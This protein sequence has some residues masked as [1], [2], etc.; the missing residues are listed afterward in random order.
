[1]PVHPSLPGGAPENVGTLDSFATAAMDHGTLVLYVRAST[2]SHGLLVSR[3]GGKSWT[4][5]KDR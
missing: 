2:A 4:A 1:V 5:E 3:D